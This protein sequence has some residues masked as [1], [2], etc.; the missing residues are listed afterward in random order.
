MS[1]GAP[2][3]SSACNVGAF[4]HGV[5]RDPDGVPKGGLDSTRDA[6]AGSMSPA[7]ALRSVP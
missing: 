4:A 2:I 7:P 6:L 1:C 3:T 5:R